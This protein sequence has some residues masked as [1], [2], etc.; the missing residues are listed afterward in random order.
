M[1]VRD[2]WRRQ[3]PLGRFSKNVTAMILSYTT[4]KDKV[5]MMLQL[6]SHDS[7]AYFLTSDDLKFYL[8][9]YLKEFE[10]L[11][12]RARKFHHLIDV[13]RLSGNL[14]YGKVEN[15]VVMGRHGTY[16]GE[17]VP[18]KGAHGHGVFTCPDNTVEGLYYNGKA[19]GL[20]YKYQPSGSR[21]KAR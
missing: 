16:E 7:R 19:N 17:Y 2:P 18:G 20:C 8:V 6:I 12:A 3:L 11:S 14:K 1:K 4:Y 15:V 5:F 21:C 13:E 10:N 9:R